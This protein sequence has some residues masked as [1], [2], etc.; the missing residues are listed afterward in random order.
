VPAGGARP[1]GEH[2]ARFGVAASPADAAARVLPREALQAQLDDATLDMCR[3]VF[4]YQVRAGRGGPRGH[5][6]S[7][8]HQEAAIL[9]ALVS[10]RGPQRRTMCRK[11]Q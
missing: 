4:A 3:L 7:R 6:S 10:R 9:V 2:L 5:A 8:G 1:L 11:E